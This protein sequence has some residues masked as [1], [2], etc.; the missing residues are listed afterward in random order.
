VENA[1]FDRGF[2]PAPAPPRGLMNNR[3]GPVG[4]DRDVFQTNFAFGRAVRLNAQSVHPGYWQSAHPDEDGYRPDQIMRY[5]EGNLNRLQIAG[6][7]HVKSG[8]VLDPERVVELDTPLHLGLLYEECSWENRSQMARTSARDFVEAVLLHVHHVRYLQEHPH[9]EIVPS[10]LQDQLLMDGEKTLQRHGT[11]ETLARLHKEAR[12]TNLDY[13]RQR[14]K[15]DWIEPETLLW[16]AWRV[17][18]AKEKAA[19]AREIVAGFVERVKEAASVD[20]RPDARKDPM[21]WHRHR[22]HPLVW[23]ALEAEP[24]ILANEKDL[25]AEL[26]RWQDRRAGYL[27]R[28]PI[29]SVAG[30]VAPWDERASP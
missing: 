11:A 22:I 8:K 16:E 24:T 12:A 25:H 18:P 9:V 6:E 15:S 26:S 2:D 4:S 5:S 3:K 29:W 30:Q 17:L 20:P 27:A 21:E 13:S 19:V 14:I 7:F 10:L 1:Y 28:R 23:Q